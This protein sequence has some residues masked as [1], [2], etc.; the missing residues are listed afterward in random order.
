MLWNERLKWGIVRAPSF[1]QRVSNDIFSIGTTYH[2]V[3]IMVGTYKYNVLVAKYL[4][5]V[6]QL[7]Q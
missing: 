4:F 3:S 2:H 5:C 1:L 7:F 6:I